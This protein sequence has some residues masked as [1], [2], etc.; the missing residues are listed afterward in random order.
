MSHEILLIGGVPS[1]CARARR[2]RILEH[3]APRVPGAVSWSIHENGSASLA[4]VVTEP[5][6][7][8]VVH[9]EDDPDAGQVIV[10]A[11]SDQALANVSSGLA[12]RRQHGAESGHIRVV[13]GRDGGV[14]VDTD[15]VGFIPAFWSAADGEFRFSTHLASLVSIGVSVSP[16]DIGVLEYLVMLHPLHHR[17]VLR[18]ARLLPAGGHILVD[19]GAAPQ[20]TVERLYVPSDDRMRDDDAVEEFR[21]I[22]S[23]VHND[24]LVRIGDQR[25]A[26]GLS[27][28]LDSRAIAA[29]CRELGFRPFTFTYGSSDSYE[30]RV[31]VDLAQSLE[32]DHA[33]L[34][35]TQERLFWGSGRAVALLDGAHSPAE[36]YEIWFEDALCAFA[37]VLINGLAGGPIWGDDKAMG[38]VG[39]KRIIE[40][41][42]RK[43]QSELS[44][45]RRFLT[46]EFA[47]ASEGLYREGLNESMDEWDMSARSDMVVFWRIHN[48]QF[49]WG[50]ALTNLLRRLGMR[51]EAPFLDSR[52]L[53]FSARL[54]PEQRL[55]GRL[56]LRVHR[57]VFR[58]VAMLPRAND[59]NAPA[60]LSHAYWSGESPYTRQLAVLAARHPVSAGRRAVR[61]LER[62]AVNRVPEWPVLAGFRTKRASRRDVFPADVWLKSSSV[63]RDRL[64][65]L[66]ESAPWLQIFS[67]PALDRLSQDIRTGRVA[68]GAL[69][70]AKVATLQV[71]FNDYA[72]RERQHRCAA[73]GL[74]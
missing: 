55:N 33:M 50:N 64:L 24:M 62:M 7:G 34:P 60:H 14:R 15:G 48:R 52:V 1:E 20:V 67:G 2:V 5:L 4:L 63:Y 54:T 28:G 3:A 68:G 13:L 23:T 16:D 29:E 22:W 70:I 38:I 44:Q 69:L 57:E 45:L 10:V 9:V 11:A 12:G 73:S 19:P 41:Q 32:F 35:L 37:D 36:T 43:N 17:T 71:W 42:M 46:P 30:G 27:G 65:E 8:T 18:N 6:G 51:A 39:R 59:G 61:Q 25:A 40:S 31:A 47:E 56:H 58:S 21:A 26:L 66:L 72:E 53:R 49:R 74:A